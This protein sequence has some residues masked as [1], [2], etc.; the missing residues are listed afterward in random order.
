MRHTQ[1]LSNLIHYSAKR[2]ALLERMQRDFGNESPRSLRPLCPTRWTIKHKTFQSVLMNY[3][4]L[5]GTLDTISS[6]SEGK[7]CPEIRSKAGGVYRSL[8]TFDYF[9]GI[10][11]SVKIFWNN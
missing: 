3:E 11:L 5:L 1:E 9:F 7:S 6:G 10:F 4:P 8:Q 2:Q